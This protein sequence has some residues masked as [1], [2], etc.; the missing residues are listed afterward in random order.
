MDLVSPEKLYKK[1]TYKDD[2]QSRYMPLKYTLMGSFLLLIIPILIAMSVSDYLNAKADLESAYTQLQKQT[3]DNIV[4]AVRL[5]EAGYK[6]VERALSKEMRQSFP[7]FLKAYEDANKNPDKMDLNALKKQLGD[8]MD[9]YVINAE[10]IVEHTTYRK[11][12]GLDFKEKFPKFFEDIT[13]YREKGGFISPPIATEARTG[14]IRHFTYMATPDHKYLLELG[15]P[16]DEFADLLGDLDLSKI[17]T[18][19]KALNPSL[20]SIR[21]FNKN[22]S[23]LV[24]SKN[25]VSQEVK[26]IINQVYEQQMTH[27]IKDEHKKQYLRYIFLNLKA[28]DNPDFD[29]SKVI[30]LNYNRKLID[31]GLE[32]TAAFHIVL[33]IIAIILSII[34]TFIIS[35]WIT[36]PIK[37]LVESVNIVAQGNLNY[38]IEVKANNELKMLR[39]SVIIM[40]ESIRNFIDQI[41]QLKR[42]G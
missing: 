29:H 28:D 30:E 31:E 1:I 10:G 38:P 4:N 9:L 22:G 35:G 33:S 41:K 37:R 34:F 3:E 13:T 26:R 42:T 2:A 27:E 7:F 19:L 40:V 16:F 18:R 36:T 20:N 17:T 39:Q 6:V 15:L 25:K 24:D 5:V 14:S 23:L 21:I 11:D 8:R 12:T 32:R